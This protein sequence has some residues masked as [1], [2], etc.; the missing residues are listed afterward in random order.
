MKV[1]VGGRVCKEPEIVSRVRPKARGC[2]A[3]CV[4]KAYGTS[5]K[6]TSFVKSN[7]PQKAVAIWSKPYTS[8]RLFPSQATV[9]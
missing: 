3:F 5:W 7:S 8:K 2:E 9:P 6:S 1:N 4:S